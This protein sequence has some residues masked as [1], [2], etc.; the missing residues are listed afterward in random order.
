MTPTELITRAERLAEL[1][2]DSVRDEFLYV[3]DTND[4]K[5]AAQVLEA[6]IIEAKEEERTGEVRDLGRG[7]WISILQTKPD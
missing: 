6:V 5:L 4:L 2:E 3:T 1:F 7:Y